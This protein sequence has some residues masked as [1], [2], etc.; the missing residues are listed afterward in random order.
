MTENDWERGEWTVPPESV[1]YEDG[2]LIATAQ[3]E[4]DAW[5]TTAY[6]Y[7]TD[8]AHA[9]L[10]PFADALEVEV[11]FIADL[12]AQFD[13][14]GLMLRADA[15]HWIKAGVEFADGVLQLGAVVTRDTSDWSSAPVATWSGR[16]V[17]ISASRNGDGVIVRAHVDDEPTGIIRVAWLD[18][19]LELRAGPYLAAPTRAGLSVRFTGWRTLDSDGRI[20]PDPAA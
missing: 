5:R 13:Q 15:E 16:S 12:S 1:R 9:L 11:S 3:P 14:A 10:A 4:S 20:H 8:S 17:T 18:P 6:G 7:V 2:D 19:N